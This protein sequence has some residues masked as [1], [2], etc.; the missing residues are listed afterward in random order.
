MTTFQHYSIDRVYKYIFDLASQKGAISQEVKDL[1]ESKRL[2]LEDETIYVRKTQNGFSGTVELLPASQGYAR[3]TTNLYDRKLPANT[4]FFVSSIYVGFAASA[5]DADA[6]VAYT[7]LV[8]GVVAA[9][10]NGHLRI[11]QGSTPVIDLPLAGFFCNA[12]AQ[13]SLKDQ[14]TALTDIRHFDPQQDIEVFIDCADGQ[15]SPG[16][17]SIEV[18]L[19]GHK[20]K[21]KVW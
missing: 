13:G 15:T 5:A 1:I 19:F 16:N 6:A 7:S 2:K 12:A 10:R 14:S 17:D 20:T 18:L 11:T 8:T 21:Q 3:G 4:Y 9:V